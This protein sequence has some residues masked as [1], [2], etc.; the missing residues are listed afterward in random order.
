MAFSRAGLH[1]FQGFS[2]QL[3]LPL[4]PAADGSFSFV[5]STMGTLTLTPTQDESRLLVSLKRHI[6]RV[7]AKL[8]TRALAH[9]GLDPA[10]NRI[11]HVGL[12]ADDHIHVTVEV[13]DHDFDLPTLDACIQHLSVLHEK[14]T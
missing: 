7:D 14:I 2:E 12:S 9:G 8:L 5:F 13:A 6:A 3:G 10:T 11:A 4:R 1:V